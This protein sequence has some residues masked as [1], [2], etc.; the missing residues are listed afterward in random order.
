MKSVLIVC[1]ANICRSAMGEGL[2]KQILAEKQ[3]TG[4]TVR[5]AGISAGSGFTAS[6]NAIKVMRELGID[7]SGHKSSPITV[8]LIENS[9]I[10]LAMEQYHKE[11]IESMFPEANGKVRLVREFAVDTKNY[12]DI[13]DPIGGTLETYRRCADE[14]RRCLLNFVAEYFT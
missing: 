6:A 12:L 3:I 10:I 11:Y 8:S 13:E 2:L 9:D 4:V 7:I 14:I 5:S 1:T